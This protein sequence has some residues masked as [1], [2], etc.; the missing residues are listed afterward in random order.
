MT[1]HKLVQEKQLASR[2]DLLLQCLE[3]SVPSEN[4]FK[5]LV[6]ETLKYH[7]QDIDMLVVIEMEVFESLDVSVALLGHSV[8]K[9]TQEQMLSFA[10]SKGMVLHAEMIARTLFKR[11]LTVREIN[12]LGMNFNP[13][14]KTPHT[15][16][17]KMAELI[18]ELP[19]EWFNKKNLYN[20]LLAMDNFG[21]YC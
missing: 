13:E 1:N 7:P 18:G 17:G 12:A 21:I 6:S 5:E 8:T 20:R 9:D 11:S 4:R 15:A 16:F 2:Q 14:S 10:L 19:D 3:N